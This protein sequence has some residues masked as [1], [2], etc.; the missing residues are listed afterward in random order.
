[1]R[2]KQLRRHWFLWNKPHILLNLRDSRP[3]PTW[4]YS[5]CPTM[6]RCWNYRMNGHRGQ[7]RYS[8]SYS[9]QGR[10]PKRGRFEE[11]IL[12]YFRL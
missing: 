6:Q 2:P 9:D 10:N 12:V 3:P 1:V 7:Y 11:W 5:L 8:P 4:D